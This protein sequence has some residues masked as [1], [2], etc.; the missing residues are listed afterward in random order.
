MRIGGCNLGIL[1]HSR[2]YLLIVVYACVCLLDSLLYSIASHFSMS[3]LALWCTWFIM[4]FTE[5]AWSSP[6][7]FALSGAGGLWGWFA[8]ARLV[9][10]KCLTD[11]SKYVIQRVYSPGKHLHK[12]CK[13]TNW[14]KKN[15]FTY[16]TRIV[17][18]EPC[19]FHS[20]STSGAF[21]INFVFMNRRSGKES[22]CSFV[23]SVWRAHREFTLFS[24]V[25]QDV[26]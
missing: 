8:I 18:A 25:R 17:D 24:I 26:D 7:A 3:Q 13:H 6:N 2:D 23:C 22:F 14:R 11:G 10:L 20:V 15:S 9:A 21:K 19:S 16:L 5:S 12:K 4:R 1:R